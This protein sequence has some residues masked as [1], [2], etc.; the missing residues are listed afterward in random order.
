MTEG[1]GGK[2]ERRL[3]DFIKFKQGWSVPA[4]TRQYFGLKLTFMEMWPRLY[5]GHTALAPPPM[6]GY[7]YLDDAKTM[8]G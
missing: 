8:P 6:G 5:L 7:C 4:V 3:T 2:R 1:P